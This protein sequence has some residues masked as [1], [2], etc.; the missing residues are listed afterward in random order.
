MK[1]KIYGLENMNEDAARK[2][3]KNG[4]IVSSITKSQ[5]EDCFLVDCIAT[6]ERPYKKKISSKKIVHLYDMGYRPIEIANMLKCSTVAVN[7]V[8][9]VYKSLQEDDIENVEG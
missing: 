3:L 8:I 4:L 9:R 7:Q 6:K 1:L 5:E 2:T